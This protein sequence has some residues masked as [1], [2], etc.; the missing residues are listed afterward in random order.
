MRKLIILTFTVTLLILQGQTTIHGQTQIPEHAQLR[1]IPQTIDNPD[2][3]PAPVHPLPS[4]RQLLWQETEFY[5]FF[6]YGMNTYTDLEWGLGSED[7]ALFAPTQVPN[8]KQ[9]LK[10]VKTAGMKGGIAVA[11]HHDGFCL[12]PTKT[13]EHNV[14]KGGN[15][16]ARKTNIPR[17][18]AK[19]ARKLKM[20]YGFYVSPWDR[21][22]AYYGTDRYVKDVFLHQ[23]HEL[24]QYGSDQFEM[25]LDGANG[26]D[27]FYGG[28]NTTVSVDRDTYYDVPNLRDSVH[29]V[30]P[31]CVL[32]GMGGE[33]RWIGNEAGWAG[34]TNW[35]T[36]NRGY[37]PERN[38]AYGMENGWAWYPGESDA[39]ATDKGWFW[40]EGEKMISAERLFQMYLETIGRNASLILNCPPDRRGLLPDNDVIVLRELGKMIKNRLGNNLA[41]KAKI[42]VSDT[43]TDGKNTKSRSKYDIR[44]AVDG[45][46]NTYWATNDGVKTATITLNWNKS[47]QIRYVQLMEYIRLGQRIRSFKIEY[48][49][50]GID[51]WKELAEN[52]GRTT[53]GYKRIIPLNGSTSNSYSD[54]GYA[55]KALR[56]TITDSKAAILLS[57]IS[58]F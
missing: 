33:A 56:I 17:D 16:F 18:F 34:E 27:G 7:E 14:T 21:N 58:V 52:V 53:V 12:W 19:A 29:K 32:W 5:A 28:R 39:K 4:K 13:T 47:Q 2:N 45:N 10:V 1:I 51:G 41:R 6:H 38:G 9:W 22:S 20:K 55:A 43:R 36:E 23:C 8:P 15:E 49:E 57:N 3:E 50:N 26:G 42:S 54:S 30:C 46:K 44:N 48:S 31:N 40:H 11:K 37:S 35:S 24:A 25:W